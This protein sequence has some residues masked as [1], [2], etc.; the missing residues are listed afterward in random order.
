MRASWIER[1]AS[2]IL[3]VLSIV[4]IPLVVWAAKLQI[5][6]CVMKSASVMQEDH[7]K[8]VQSRLDRQTQEIYKD[9][10]EVREVV[11]RI[12]ATLNVYK[13]KGIVVMNTRSGGTCQ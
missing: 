4:V 7:R 1:N 8:E 10:K 5:D 9:I 3:A 11:L 2:L 13:D 12:D 6:I